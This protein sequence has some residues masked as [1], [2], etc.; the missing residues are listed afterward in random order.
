[1][2]TG[3][4]FFFF[5]FL[6]CLEY[7]LGHRQQVIWQRL[8]KRLNLVLALSL[9]VL[10]GCVQTHV[11]MKFNLPPQK[12]PK[13]IKNLQD[14]HK[15]IETKEY[16]ALAPSKL[17]IQILFNNTHAE[18]LKLFKNLLEAAKNNPPKYVSTIL[19][20]KRLMLGQNERKYVGTYTSILGYISPAHFS[21]S[22]EVYIKEDDEFSLGPLSVYMKPTWKLRRKLKQNEI[23]LIEN[24][25]RKLIAKY[26]DNYK[27]KCPKEGEKS[28]VTRGSISIIQIEGF[29]WLFVFLLIVSFLFLCL[30][31]TCKKG[32]LGALRERYISEPDFH[33]GWGLNQLSSVCSYSCEKATNTEVTSSY[34]KAKNTE[35]TSSYEK[36]T[37]TE[38]TLVD[39]NLVF[40]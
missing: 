31:F 30:K 28:S 27:T 16:S 2:F 39:Q 32:Q 38:I 17:I 37:N 5:V 21:N 3:F 11:V 33:R 24:E 10:L 19:E 6:V 26:G 35:V 29:M 20:A 34:E 23:R 8:R 36:A 13:P 15:A 22:C 14:L 12:I 4:L 1:M 40:F 7:F 25:R 18:K 9:T